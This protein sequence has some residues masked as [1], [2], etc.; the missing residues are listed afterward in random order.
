MYLKRDTRKSGLAAFTL[1]HP[2]DMPLPLANVQNHP[3]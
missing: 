3:A 2:H 1:E